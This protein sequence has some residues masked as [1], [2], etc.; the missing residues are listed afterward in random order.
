MAEELHRLLKRQIHRTMGPDFTPDARMR[1]LLDLVDDYYRQVE[2]DR[3]LIEN[4]LAVSSEELESLYARLRDRTD[5]ERAI[6]RSFTTSVPDLLFVKAVD[7][8]YQTCNPAFERLLGLREDQVLGR[9]VHDV[10]PGA[11]AQEISAIEREVLASGRSDLREQWIHLPNGEER[12]LEM[13]RAPYFGGDGRTLGLIGIGRDVTDR[14]RLEEQTRL[15]ALVYRNSGEGMLVTDAEYRIVDMNPACERITGYALDE[16]RGRTPETFNS[17]RQDRAFYES[18]RDT[19]ARLGHWHGEVWDRRKSG[20]THVKSMTVSRIMDAQGGVHGYVM[21]FSDVTQRKQA[22][23]MIWRQANFDMLTGLPNRRMLR[24]RLEHEMRQADRARCSLALLLLDL[25]HF[26]EI[27]DTLGHQVG[28][29]LLVE[30]ARRIS[31]CTRETDT[32]ARL[33]GDEFIV[34]LTRLTDARHAETVATKIIERLAEPFQLGDTVGYVSASIGI[35]LYPQDA[36]E[37]DD[38][39]KGADQAMYVAKRQGRNRFSHFTAGL[40]TAAQ[41]RLRLIA[42]LR[43]AVEHDEFLLHFQP[44]V[45]AATGHIHKAEALVRWDHP[46]RGTVGPEEFIRIAEETGLIVPIGDWVFREATR[47]AAR[48]SAIIP[49]FQVTVNVSPVQ[50]RAEAAASRA[51]WIECVS[52]SSLSPHAMVIEITEGLLLQADAEVTDT[53]KH[54]RQAGI[55]IAVDDFGTGYSSLAYLHRFD[56][57]LLKIDQA[58][59]ASLQTQASNGALCE[60]IIV[61]AHKLGLKVVA[62]GVE[63]Q[64]QADLLSSAGCDSMQ[65]FLFSRPLPPEQLEAILRHGAVGR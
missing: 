61:M 47:W 34:I 25:D 18:M 36:R 2:R 54:L 22:D 15:A 16:V 48:W 28:D 52:G 4:A 63:T 57:D 27:N 56:I 53:L 44:V 17:G 42:D 21:L 8:V 55:G 65:G 51:S 35:T 30:S 20:E 5:A 64:V 13:L 6:F 50:F 58:F 37:A 43:E 9:T 7:G 11:M 26:K 41:E 3:S 31:A 24:E 10:L 46:A 38:L 12:C 62:E 29:D 39:L 59:V 23:D 14:R 33:G 19:V 49:G 1:A 32:V 45:D 40:Q 60:A